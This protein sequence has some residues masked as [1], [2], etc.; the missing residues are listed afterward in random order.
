[1]QDHLQ[2]PRFSRQPV[3]SLSSSCCLTIHSQCFHAL[4]PC[5]GAEP[6]HGGPTGPHLHTRP[7]QWTLHPGVRMRRPHA[8]AGQAPGV[9]SGPKIASWRVCWVGDTMLSPP[10]WWRRSAALHHRA[11]VVAVKPTCRSSSTDAR[12]ITSYRRW[13]WIRPG[14]TRCHG[15]R[16]QPPSKSAGTRKAK[17]LTSRQRIQTER[18]DR[19]ELSLPKQLTVGAPR[20]PFLHTHT[21]TRGLDMHAT[22]TAPAP[23][24]S[25]PRAYPHLCFRMRLV[26]ID[27]R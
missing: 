22:T 1:M 25:V 21:M 26:G 14:V 3:T 6:P 2:L 5:C 9:C 17:G 27:Q 13:V 4:R 10:A 20:S 24:T 8:L 16:H 18:D 12:G 11:A 19:M 23:T 7:G 15:N